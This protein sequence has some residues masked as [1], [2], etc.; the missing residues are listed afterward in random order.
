MKIVHV[1]PLYHPFRGGAESY[2]KEVSERLARRGHD[3]TVLALNRRTQT[4]QRNVPTEVLNSVTVRRFEPA[5]R[6]QGVL[7][8]A[9]RTGVGRRVCGWTAYGDVVESW[10][11]SS[12]GLAAFLHAVRA[13]PDVVAVIN[14]YDGWLPLQ[15]CLARRLRRFALVGVPLF[16]TEAQWARE[17]LQGKLLQQFDAIVAMTDHERAFALP[18]TRRARPI[19]AGVDE[20]SFLSADGNAIRA[21][22]GIGDAPLV[23][24][25]GRMAAY[26]GVDSLISA[27]K[28]VWRLVPD[29]RLLL[30]GGGGSRSDAPLGFPSPALD[31][32]SAAE[33]ARVIIT[34][35]FSDDEKSSLFD[36]LDV[37]AMPSRA[38]SFGI[39]YLEAWLRHKPVI[40]A[41]LGSTEC[42]IDHGADGELVAPD[43]SSELAASILRLLRDRDRRVRFGATGHAKTI[44]RFTWDRVTDAI[45]R[46][47]QETSARVASNAAV[48]S[49]P[50]PDDAAL[51]SS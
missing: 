23:G 36:S 43:D 2:T 47:Y 20:A 32:L 3:V 35:P 45:E 4:G 37:F 24:Y 28:E 1:T 6:V 8:I 21:R 31:S 44:A 40:G 38:E 10:A 46:L 18:F 49:E 34:G 50:E 7:A 41:R 16:H 26:K 13:R 27:M 51:P 29:A 5:G 19:G 17:P 14:W 33:R 9:A 42:I 11:G 30:A 12:Y 39:S 22:Y 48:T 15:M 25:I